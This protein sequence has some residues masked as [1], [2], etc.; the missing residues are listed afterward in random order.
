MSSPHA[1]ITYG[2]SYTH[3]QP[4][5]STNST[6]PTRKI[7]QGKLK[8]KTQ[9]FSPS[10][11]FSKVAVTLQ[12]KKFP[13]LQREKKTHHRMLLSESPQWQCQQAWLQQQCCPAQ[14]LDHATMGLS[15]VGGWRNPEGFKHCSGVQQAR[16]STAGTPLLTG[17]VG[18]TVRLA[19]LTLC[20]SGL[21]K[22][23]MQWRALVRG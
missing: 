21:G 17:T 1:T 10:P 19:S 16:N 20:I 18:C 13:V 8:Q 4:L 6:A 15:Q 7:S 9:L 2:P 3:L 23:G 11:W 12:G 22:R 14:G 5:L